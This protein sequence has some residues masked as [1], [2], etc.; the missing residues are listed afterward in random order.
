MKQFISILAMLA[1]A[2]LCGAAHAQETFELNIVGGRT[3]LPQYSRHERPFW[4]ETIP[5]AT[6]GRITAQISSQDQLGF[7]GHEIFRLIGTGVVD[8]GSSVLAYVGSD[9]PINEGIDLAGLS[10][11]VDAAKAVSD[12][13]IPVID[14]AY[15]ARHGIKLLAVWGYPGQ[16]VFCR[17]ELT[18]LAD[19]RGRNVRTGNRSLAEFMLAIGANSIA[20]PIADVVPALERGVVDCAITGTLTAY[21]QKWHETI[22]YVYDLPLAWSQVALAINLD[23]W[24]RM[25]EDLQAILIEQADKLSSDIWAEV[26]SQTQSGLDCLTGG[27]C[28]YGEA[29]DVTLVSYSSEDKELVNETLR[30][31]I[32]PSWA[33]RCGDTCAENW[34]AT[35][36]AVAGLEIAR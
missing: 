23:V 14:E 28:A 13:W 30:S 26:G 2:N 29:A 20:M 1:G 19:I 16:V 27:E 11:D 18:S 3:D 25:P 7:S 6:D 24:N 10:A 5:A 4:S 8:A 12:A 32:L 34:N 15:Q 17:D 35:V 31:S 33:G 22:N 21:N 36:G 9:D